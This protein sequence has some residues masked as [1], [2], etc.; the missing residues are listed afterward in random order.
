M[1]WRGKEETHYEEGERKKM[2]KT[3]EEEKEKKEGREKNHEEEK[4]VRGISDSCNDSGNIG[5]GCGESVSKY[6]NASK[7]SMN[8]GKHFYQCLSTASR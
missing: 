7:L 2:I 5:Q 3:K 6:H 1:R 4:V 8:H